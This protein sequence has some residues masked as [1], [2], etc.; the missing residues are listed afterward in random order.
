MR[1]PFYD[2]PGGKYAEAGEQL[3]R[4]LELE[5]RDKKKA[6]YDTSDWTI[7]MPGV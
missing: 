6:P 2:K 1:L 7:H 4:Y 3:K 5:H